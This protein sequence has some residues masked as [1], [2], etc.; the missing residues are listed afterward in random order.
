[1]A[2]VLYRSSIIRFGEQCPRVL[3]HVFICHLPANLAERGNKFWHMFFT[4]HLPSNLADSANKTVFYLSFTIKYGEQR[5]RVLARVFYLS[6][7]QL[8]FGLEQGQE[9][10]ERTFDP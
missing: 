9:A 4:C 8:G 1:M 3:A 10:K 7:K 2:H 6:S 5:Q